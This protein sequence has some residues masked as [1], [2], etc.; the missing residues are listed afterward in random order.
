MTAQHAGQFNP[1]REW[2]NILGLAYQSY[3]RHR[4]DVRLHVIKPVASATEPLKAPLRAT[5]HVSGT[6]RIASTPDKPLIE[7][8]EVVL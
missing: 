4:A 3:P 8:K 5:S 7:N 1:A 6:F 2:P